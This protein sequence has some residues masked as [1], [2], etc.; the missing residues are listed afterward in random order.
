MNSNNIKNLTPN[1]H[2]MTDKEFKK[3]YKSLQKESNEYT[4]KNTRMSLKIFKLTGNK[5]QRPKGTQKADN[6]LNRYKT[7]L[8]LI[9]FK[10]NEIERK[11]ISLQI[12]TDT[13]N[14]LI[15]EEDNN[16]NDNNNNNNNNNNNIDNTNKIKNNT[17]SDSDS[18]SDSNS[19]I[20]RKPLLCSEKNMIINNNRLFLMEQQEEKDKQYEIEYD[21]Y[22]VEILGY[23]R[24]NKSYKSY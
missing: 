17:D 20:K 7:Q 22:Q 4:N 24:D 21:M 1:I 3:I 23:H 10:R 2:D 14:N 8:E 15:L 18:D 19:N 9:D 11:K 16:D 5:T 6:E 12:E 13:F